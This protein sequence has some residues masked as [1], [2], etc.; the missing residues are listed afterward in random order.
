MMGFIRG[1]YIV[2]ISRG[3]VELVNQPCGIFVILLNEVDDPWIIS[4]MP[5]IQ[6]HVTM[7]NTKNDAYLLRGN[8]KSV[9]Y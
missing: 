4:R 2:K 8:I 6:K 1:E 9:L 5:D 7:C 3:I